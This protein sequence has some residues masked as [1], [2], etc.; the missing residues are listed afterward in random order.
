[1]KFSGLSFLKSEVDS[2]C[3][4][5]GLPADFDRCVDLQSGQIYLVPSTLESKGYKPMSAVSV[6]GRVVFATRESVRVASL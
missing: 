1:M 3:K 6:E 5:K 4:S 2:Y